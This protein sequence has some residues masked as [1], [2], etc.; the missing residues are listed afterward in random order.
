LTWQHYHR[1]DYDQN[2]EVNGADIVRIAAHFN[3]TVDGQDWLSVIDGNGDGLINIIDITPIGQNFKTESASYNVYQ[4]S[5]ES[6][7]F[8]KIGS[9]PFSSHLGDPLL[10]RISF[11]FV[12]P[13]PFPGAWYY[14]V[15]VDSAGAEGT[16]SNIVGAP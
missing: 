12:V 5:S 13:S 9:V 3:E 2:G 7:P 6:G 15:H 16:M 11:S 4:G 14:V 8:S 10:D 1:G